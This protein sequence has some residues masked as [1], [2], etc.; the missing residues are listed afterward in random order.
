MEIRFCAVLVTGDGDKWSSLCSSSREK[1]PGTNGIRCFV[2]PNLVAYFHRKWGLVSGWCIFSSV[3]GLHPL[4]HFKW[5]TRNCLT[6]E[7]L[8]PFSMKHTT[9]H[10][11]WTKLRYISTPGRSL[12]WHCDW[13]NFVQFSGI[14]SVPSNVHQAER[15]DYIFTWAFFLCVVAKFVCFR[16]YICDTETALLLACNQDVLRCIKHQCGVKIEI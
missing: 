12:N 3:L 5:K 9:V 16:E 15:Q 1:A 8:S 14:R 2:G 6:I 7:T 4:C 10:G 11:F 13:P